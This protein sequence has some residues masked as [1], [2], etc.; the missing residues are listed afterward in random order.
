ME[1]SEELEQEESFQFDS[2]PYENEDLSIDLLPN[3][4]SPESLSNSTLVEG[5]SE[6]P[7]TPSRRRTLDDRETIRI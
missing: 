5:I 2:D 4:F 1:G 6:Q 7:N 3:S